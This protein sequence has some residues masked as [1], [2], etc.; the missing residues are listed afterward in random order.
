MNLYGGGLGVGHLDYGSV[1]NGGIVMTAVFEY[2][3]PLFFLAAGAGLQSTQWFKDIMADTDLVI[4]IMA[5]G[6]FLL[7]GENAAEIG[8]GGSPKAVL[9][10]SAS[11][12]AGLIWSY[13]CK[14]LAEVLVEKLTESE[15]EGA[16]P[17][18]GWA[19]RVLSISSTLSSLTQTTAEV[20]SS[21]F[22]IK[23]D[24]SPSMN[25]ELT[26]KHDENDYQFPATASTF[27]VRAFYTDAN[28]R[29]L[30]TQ[31]M[32]TTTASE[33]IVVDLYG[34]PAG[35]TVEVHV[36]FY[37]K[38]WWLVGAGTTGRIAN[39]V[40]A[41][42]DKLKAEIIITEF[43][44]PLTGD[45]Q[46]SH[47]QK[48]GYV[49]GAYKWIAS[50]A[51][52]KTL[53]ALSC[54]NQGANLCMLGD[55]TFSQKTG[56]FGYTW[57]ASG[58]NMKLCDTGT[59]DMQL[60]YVQSMS[61]NADPQ[62]AYKSLECGMSSPSG[63]VYELLG[64][65]DGSGYNFFIDS[66]N[67]TY[68]LRKVVLD[69]TT[70]MTYAGKSWGRFTQ[71]LDDVAMRDGG[72]IVGANWS[73]SKIELLKIPDAPYED[74]VA[75]WAVVM[76]GEGAREGLLHGPKAIAFT[77]TGELLVLETVN[78]RIQ[79]LDLDGNPVKYFNDKA[80]YFVSLKEETNPVMYLDMG[81]E[82]SGYIYVLSY[83]KNG[84]SVNDYRLDIYDTKGKFLARTVGVAAHRMA[85]DFWRNVY[86]LNYEAI[87]GPGGRTEP[88]VSE[89]IPST[90]A[91]TQP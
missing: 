36:A 44:V 26:I 23:N 90:P 60:Y 34:L 15:M 74:S 33:P 81:V 39:K 7:A 55:V 51:P 47:K 84:S 3:I 57:Q 75:P 73:N 48:L 22:V 10:R 56:M 72:Y 19:M 42:S 76:A 68:H 29:L 16:V 5:V 82:F 2:G 54:G 70:K 13:G 61:A 69:T 65:D 9:S 52:A 66:R 43:E 67:G 12:I 46:Y 87:A 79:A 89:W 18:V 45:T 38:N 85:V 62:S 4:A 27:E 64:P 86:T 30:K 24:V 8:F 78:R 21:P 63:I 71:P 53:S 80:D 14:K 35:G 1:A 20:L 6:G 40:S 83:E 77:A 37:S 41:G 11:M 17:F 59:K 25:M 88:S 58:P 91:G 31:D 50:G 32:P 49:A 28:H